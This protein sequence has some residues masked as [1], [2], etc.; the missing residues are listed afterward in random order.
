MNTAGKSWDQWLRRLT[1]GS[2]V[3]LV[4]A[5]GAAALLRLSG[6]QIATATA[7]MGDV[8]RGE[9]LAQRL[10]CYACHI[11]GKEVA[12]HYAAHPQSAPDLRA[13]AA[14]LTREVAYAQ[15]H[16][17][18]DVSEHTLM[19]AYFG[20]SNN[21]DPASLERGE[22]EVHAMVHYLFVN[23]EQISLP[24]PTGG[25]DAARGKNLVTSKG[26]LSCHADEPSVMSAAELADKFQGAYG[27]N[28]FVIGRKAKPE[29]IFAFI[30]SPKRFAP[31]T[32][33]PDLALTDQEAADVTAYLVDKPANEPA[34][35][36]LPAPPAVDDVL[37]DDLAF[38]YLSKTTYESEAIRQ[39]NTWDRNA[40]LYYLG[41]RLV[42]R[43]GCYGCHHIKGFEDAEPNGEDLV[44][45]RDKRI[46][47]TG[48]GVLEIPLG[49][50]SAARVKLQDPRVFEKGLVFDPYDR[51]IMPKF[52]LQPREIDDLAAFVVNR[53]A[54]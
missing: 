41:F 17:P 9:R 49:H 24:A 44:K 42:R 36:P 25:G 21:D 40:K 16:K 38:D 34:H 51:L 7:N 1:F 11:L 33:M 35:A 19:P 22:E 43:Y 39:I 15:I 18:S 48:F 45:W 29:W 14:K 3:A 53:G 6:A 54:Q 46:N 13:V 28:F 31:T 50:Y 26:C 30:K 2:A 20:Q 37:L 32:P 4:S 8:Q 52:A 10:N 27:G 47:M 5:L 23:S 12:S